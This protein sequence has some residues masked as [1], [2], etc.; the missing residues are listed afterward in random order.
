MRGLTGLAVAGLACLA[1]AC[2]SGGEVVLDE[3]PADNGGDA[4]FQDVCS[5][6]ADKDCDGKVQP[7]NCQKAA[8]DACG[9]TV[10][11][12]AANTACDDGKADTFDD[13]CDG[14]GVCVGRPASCGDKKCDAAAEN[15]GNCEDCACQ[16][17]K[18]IC[19]EN[20]CIAAPVNNNG[21]C[22][23]TEN[24]EANPKDCKCGAGKGCFEKQCVA[25]ADFCKSSGRECG[26]VDN[27]NCGDCPAGKNCDAIGHCYGN[28]ICNN[29]VCEVGENCGNCVSDCACPIG[30]TCQG[31]KC[32]DCGPIC[33]AA[34]KDCGQYGA[35]DCGACAVCHQCKANVCQP[36]CDCLCWPDSGPN[37][38]QCGEIEGCKCGSLAG[39]CPAG[40]EC[41]GYKCLEGCD[42][43]CAG[44][45]CG[46]A[47]DCICAWCDGCNA[48]HGNKCEAG[49]TVDE[50]EPN[51]TI[52]DAVDL[53]SVIDDPVASLTEVTGS[54]DVD[55]DADWYKLE[56]TDTSEIWGDPKPTV[57]LTGLAEDK[58]LDIILC[59]K[60]QA[61]ALVGAGVTP[62]DATVEIESPFPMTRCWSTLNLWG[63]DES[64][65][66]APTCDNGGVESGTVYVGVIPYE[67]YD[68]GSGYKLSIHM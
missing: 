53:G 5:C 57:T 51:D 26:T 34:G 68:C 36:K 48:C 39:G 1:W 45:E 42:T 56:V 47:E 24:C 15:C 29:G 64:I 60:C 16:K 43:L 50:Y 55:W 67:T 27:C 28:S 49:A 23:P 20:A 32:E 21:K 58:D 35:C 41:Y 4:V 25:C 10:K 52:S 11:P 6:A 63:Q 54:I 18:Q 7:N 14:K 65:T 59:F 22:E 44:K 12:L 3:G 31:D 30:K 33:K 9:C 2:S 13:K 62:T 37:A 8:C 66:L 40:Q 46:W 19:F 38:K 61:G 17:D